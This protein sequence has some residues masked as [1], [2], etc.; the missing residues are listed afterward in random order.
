M[1]ILFPFLSPSI[2]V[3][4]R[5]G[6]LVDVFQFDLNVTAKGKMS[7]TPLRVL[8]TGAAGQIGYALVLQIAKGD[9]F[10]CDQVERKK[11]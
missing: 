9:V 8:V 10:G 2:A 3:L 6:R 4:L 5:R 1:T 7:K 11:S